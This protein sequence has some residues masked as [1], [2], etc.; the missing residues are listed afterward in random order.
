MAL[1]TYPEFAEAYR[2]MDLPEHCHAGFADYVIKGVPPGGFLFAL[3]T[4]D[5]RRTFERADG[6]N[7]KRILDYLKFLYSDC[8]A[9]CWGSEEAVEKWINRNGMMG[10]GYYRR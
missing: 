8:P 5:L 4:N 1:T 6:E 10:E 3:L 9:Q 2:K 7:I